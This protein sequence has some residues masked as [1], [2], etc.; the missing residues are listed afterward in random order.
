MLSKYFQFFRFL[1]FFPAHPRAPEIDM[2]ELESLFSAAAPKS[3]HGN[4]SGKSNLRAPAGSKFD[5]VQL[6]IKT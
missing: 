4:S 1:C 3:D 2:S 6:V 5:K